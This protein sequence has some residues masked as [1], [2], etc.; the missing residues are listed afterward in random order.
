MSSG[1][2][3]PDDVVELPEV[4]VAAVVER[5]VNAPVDP[6]SRQPRR[7][8]GNVLPRPSPKSPEPATVSAHGTF[9]ATVAVSADGRVNG[10]D[11]GS[12]GPNSTAPDDSASETC[13][14]TPRNRSSK[15]PRPSPLTVGRSV[16]AV[17]SG[18]VV[19]DVV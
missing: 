2:A 7:S 19:N 3:T 17:V 15:L 5:G 11:N 8:S 16:T 14:A 13:G 4:T 6:P 18:R 10:D 12:T 1:L 9:D